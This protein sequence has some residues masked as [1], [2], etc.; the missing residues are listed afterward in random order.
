M[1]TIINKYSII[2]ISPLPLGQFCH[3]YYVAFKAIREQE[4]T[5]FIYKTIIKNNSEITN[6]G[7]E[8]IDPDFIKLKNENLLSCLFNKEE[9]IIPAKA[10]IGVN[11]APM[12]LP[13]IE[14]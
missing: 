4:K 8:I 9:N 3:S 7:I 1:K 12:L 5:E 14:E 10:P 13:I 2:K 6:V 11:I